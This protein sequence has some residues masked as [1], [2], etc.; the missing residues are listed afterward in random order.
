MEYT[1]NLPDSLPHEQVI[2]RIRQLETQLQADSKALGLR[3]SNNLSDEPNSLTEENLQQK[4]LKFAEFLDWSDQNLI[5]V[6]NCQIPLREE[7]NAR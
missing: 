6:D 5:S 7:R 3:N 2:E 4:R 1:I